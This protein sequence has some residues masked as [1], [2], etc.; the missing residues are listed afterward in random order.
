MVYMY[1][2]ALAAEGFAILPGIRQVCTNLEVNGWKCLECGADREMRVPLCVVSR[3]MAAIAG[4]NVR[5]ETD[6]INSVRFWGRCSLR[7]CS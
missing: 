1:C 2:A 5:M 3:A 4:L 6:R 7:Q